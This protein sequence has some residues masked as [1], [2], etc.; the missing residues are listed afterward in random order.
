M[1]TL[2]HPIALLSTF[3]WIG[4]VSAISFMEAWLKFQ[5][6]GVS[7]EIGLGIGRLVFDALNKV[8]WI[9][10]L[11]VI[12]NLIFDKSRPTAM[13]I[14]LFSIPVILLSLQTMWLLP[15][16]DAR[17]ELIIQN[18]IPPSSNLHFYYI[19]MEVMK[20]FCLSLYGVSQFKKS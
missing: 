16:L 8:E 15:V 5:A 2:K 9:F 18:Q 4:F 12:V 13:Q 10:A 17:A 6:P 3:L 14:A 19:G 20:V 1:T 7:L 11:A